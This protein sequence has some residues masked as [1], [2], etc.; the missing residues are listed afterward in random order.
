MMDL[1]SQYPRWRRVRLVVIRPPAVVDFYSVSEIVTSLF[2]ALQALGC[3]VDIQEN[4]PIPDGMNI[5][6]RAHLLSLTAP[7]DIPPRSII[8]NLE[9][10]SD[11]SAW[12]GPM[13]RNLLSRFTV[14][15]YSR[16]NLAA[17]RAIADRRQLHLVPIGYMPQLTHVP[18]APIEDIDVLFYGS[19][20]SRRRAVLRELQQ[21]AV[22]L[23][24]ETSIR[25]NARDALISRAK[26]VLNMHFYSTAIFEMV[27]VSYLLANRKAVVSEC[28]PNTEIDSDIR[29]AIAP[30]SY[31][32]LCSTVLQL[33]H[34]DRRR[35]E[36]A[37]RGYEIFAK[38]RLPDILLQAIAETEAADC[39]SASAVERWAVVSA[40][41]SGKAEEDEP[42]RTTVRAKRVLFHAINGN[43][44]GHVVRLS[45][46]ARTLQTHAE[47]AFFSTCPFANRYWSGRLF[48]VHNR[49][50]ERFGLSAEQ[51]NL[52]G[53]HLALNKFMPDVVVFDTHWPDSIVP[54]L[55]EN[56][57]RTVLVLRALAV[58]SM[59]P[60]VRL[61]IRDFSSVL[62]PHHPIELDS[63]YGATP[64]LLGLM[65]LT[66]CVCV[67]PV[68]RTAAPTHGTRKVIFT[69]GGGGGNWQWGQAGSL[70]SFIDEFRSAARTLAENFGIEP[71]FAAGPLLDRP[72]ESF[73]PF[74]VVRSHNLHEM[75][76]PG[77]IVVTRGGYNTCWEAIAAGGRL[78]IVGKHMA[79]GVEDV[80]ARSGFLVAQGL[81]KQVRTDAAE[82]LKACTDVIA[83]PCSIDDHFLKHSI[84]GGLSLARDEI[85]GISSPGVLRRSNQR[86]EPP[87]DR[88]S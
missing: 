50:D 64:E 68:A 49:L 8:Y 26:I 52:L 67:G 79:Y 70:G 48:A 62:L 69:L 34:N 27:R 58:E 10:I 76:G 44:V 30:A 80:P 2:H 15:D 66:P 87:S 74:R 33:L 5:F 46:I 55:R 73:S 20:N 72:E 42:G 38:R 22:G 11:Q 53:F 61:A 83:H 77:D 51:R 71:I 9:Q 3:C 56:G 60:L 47:V 59:E 85:L 18:S 6:F 31:D 54:E 36:L 81:A 1:P 75:F 23:R 7:A 17:I 24:V 41:S 43:G 40:Q 4:E 25:G 13:Y 39:S 28:G 12:V 82:I 78:I 29:E 63:I 84:N 19:L 45:V 86:L 35:L 21:A 32:R 14:W 65:N 16:R 37:H 57:I 88:S